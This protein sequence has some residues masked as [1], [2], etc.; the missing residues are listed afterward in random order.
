MKRR[1]KTVIVAAALFA[2]G[3]FAWV[4]YGALFG[5]TVSGEARTPGEIPE[6]GTSLD[7]LQPR[8]PLTYV[9]FYGGRG[10]NAYVSGQASGDV[11]AAA[12]AAGLDL[13]YADPESDKRLSYLIRSH[14]QDPARFTTNFTNDDFVYH[15]AT[16]GWD[17]VEVYYRPSDGRFTARL[18]RSNDKPP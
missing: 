10:P 12:K 3:L 7:W 5:T 2:A 14:D 15:G 4:V 8:G 18:I 11:A 1:G 16:R 17:F 9:V 13:L 6:V